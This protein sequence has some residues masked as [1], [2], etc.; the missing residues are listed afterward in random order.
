MKPQRVLAVLN[1]PKEIDTTL[2]KAFEIAKLFGANIEILYI[3]DE[4][5]FEV[6]NILKDSSFNQDEI[7]QKLKESANRYIQK[8][9]AIFVKIGDSGDVVWDILRDDNSTIVVTSS[10]EAAT[11]IVQKN[12]TMLYLAQ[13]SSQI[14]KAA[15]LF[16]EIEDFTKELE[17]LKS[18]SSNIEL[19]YN[20]NYIPYSQITDPMIGVF[21]MDNLELIETQEELFET[22]KNR[23]NLNGK[24]CIN[25]ICDDDNLSQHIKSSSIDLIALCNIDKNVGLLAI[26]ENIKE[27]KKDILLL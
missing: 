22:L 18:F 5:L 2:Q 25:Y 9:I 10:I 17:L 24:I 1:S 26:Y 19:I 8:D 16:E 20:Y 11:K 6:D 14:S 23:Y 15:L 3:D 27:T 12:S 21:D 13:Q 7:A 4:P